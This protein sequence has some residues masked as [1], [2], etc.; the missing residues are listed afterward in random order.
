MHAETVCRRGAAGWRDRVDE[1]QAE[2]DKLPS[3]PEHAAEYAAARADLQ[4][5]IHIADQM[6]LWLLK[7]TTMVLVQDRMDRPL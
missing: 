1:L 3:D 4:N 7:P 2:L 6:R 5:R